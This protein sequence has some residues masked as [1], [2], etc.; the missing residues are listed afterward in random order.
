MSTWKLQHRKST[1][2]NREEIMSTKEHPDINSGLGRQ[3]KSPLAGYKAPDWRY[4]WSWEVYFQKKNRKNSQFKTSSAQH[5]LLG[6]TFEKWKANSGFQGVGSL[7]HGSLGSFYNISR[8]WF[9]LL[10]KTI[11]F[12]CA[13][14]LWEGNLA[15]RGLGNRQ[16][17]TSSQH[18]SIFNFNSLLAQP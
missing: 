16:T 17:K 2:K 1:L 10:W 18:P 8:L 12:V 3:K 14:L 15:L 6:R 5:C 11:G 7:N 13:R 9:S 4:N